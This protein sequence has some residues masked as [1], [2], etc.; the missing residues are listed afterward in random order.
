MMTSGRI[1]FARGGAGR[2]RTWQVSSPVSLRERTAAAV[3]R[4]AEALIHEATDER[5]GPGS[6]CA[7]DLNAFSR[8]ARLRWALHDRSWPS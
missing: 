3:N 2:P 8:M 5:A 1:G 4:L 6:G 7:D